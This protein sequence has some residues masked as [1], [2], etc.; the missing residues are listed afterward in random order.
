M[1]VPLPLAHARAS[2]PA[3]ALCHALPGCMCVP[4]VF[5]EPRAS[6]LA[7][8]CPN[9]YFLICAKHRHLCEIRA[10]QRSSEDWM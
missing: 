3:P 7:R 6:C 1:P 9:A 2:C 5:D 4:D 8:G 10:H